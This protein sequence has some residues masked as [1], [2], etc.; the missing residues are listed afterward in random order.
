MH[1]LTRVNYLFDKYAITTVPRAMRAKNGLCAAC[2]HSQWAFSDTFPE[3]CALVIFSHQ[4]DVH[5]CNILCG[6][7]GLRF[8][9]VLWAI[10]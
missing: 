5:I 4:L 2:L 7:L 1:T 8:C 6:E 9:I 3:T 10:V